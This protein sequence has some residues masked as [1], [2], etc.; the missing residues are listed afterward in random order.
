MIPKFEVYHSNIHSNF[1]L[2]DKYIDFLKNEYFNGYVEVENSENKNFVFLG[3]GEILS[4][5]LK[6]KEGY[7]RVKQSEIIAPLNTQSFISSYRCP[8]QYVDFFSR[9][10][11]A[12]LI[13]NGLESDILNPE[14]LLNKCKT[15]Q[16]TG[17]I[18]ADDGSKNSIYIYFYSGRFMGAMN[19][20]DKDYR[21][22]NK[23]N[24][25]TVQNKLNNT[26]INLYKLSTNTNDTKE[27]RQLLIQCYEEILQFLEKKNKKKDFSSLWRQSALELSDKY[28]F[29]DPFANEFNYEKGKIEVWDKINFNI[30]VYGLEELVNSIADK[31]K[32]SNKELKKIKNNYSNL[33]GDYEIEI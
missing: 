21:F 17:F 23:L 32:I 24:E 8:S 9:I 30:L 33:L 29:L 26:T 27:N 22:D 6:N 31:L 25:T 28:F 20:Q 16:L 14:K 19:L 5:F 10:Y 1:I 11:T 7:Q 18:E 13:Y 12:Q 4:C 15:D 3:E 2:F